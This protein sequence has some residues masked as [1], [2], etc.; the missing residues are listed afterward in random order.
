MAKNGLISIIF[1]IRKKKI[2]N[3]KPRRYSVFLSISFPFCV[4]RGIF[5]KSLV[6]E[7]QFQITNGIW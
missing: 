6:I 3:G 4:I 5:F 7:H 2:E 1:E